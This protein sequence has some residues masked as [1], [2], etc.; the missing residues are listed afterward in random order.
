M[1][2]G[3]SYSKEY[4]TVSSLGVDTSAIKGKVVAAAMGVVW[5][6]SPNELDSKVSAIRQRSNLEL[7]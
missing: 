3:E 6:D 7:W 2:A 1:R 5:E 4:D